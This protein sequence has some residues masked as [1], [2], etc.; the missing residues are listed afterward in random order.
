MKTFWNRSFSLG[1]IC[2]TAFKSTQ[3]K[4]PEKVF[5]PQEAVK[6]HFQKAI[7]HDCPSTIFEIV[8]SL[9]AEDKTNQFC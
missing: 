3:K 4:L 1:I 6:R 7:C 2:A 8:S 5:N 9:P